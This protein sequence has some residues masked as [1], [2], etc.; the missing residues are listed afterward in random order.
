[1]RA[2]WRTVRSLLSVLPERFAS[3]AKKYML[4]SSLLSV[5]DIAALA[6]VAAALPAL[7]RFGTTTT[8]PLIGDF[9]TEQD[10]GDSHPPPASRPMR[11]PSATGSSR[12][13]CARRGSNA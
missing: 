11:S 5:L 8:L 13:T 10:P 2:L 12:P 7:T 6:M 9:G 1:M 3:F 4:A